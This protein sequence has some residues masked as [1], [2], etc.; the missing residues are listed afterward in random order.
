[1]ALD[2]AH[3]N[4]CQMTLKA[5]IKNRWR[6]RRKKNWSWTNQPRKMGHQNTGSGC[7]LLSNRPMQQN[8]K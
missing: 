5:L 3:N 7:I 8:C 2:W 4:L 1:M 6:P